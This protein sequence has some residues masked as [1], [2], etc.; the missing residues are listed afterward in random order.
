MFIAIIVFLPAIAL[1]VFAGIKPSEVSAAALAFVAIIAV[2]V[3]VTARSFSR[4]SCPR[5]GE[6]FAGSRDAWSRRD[7]LVLRKCTH[8]DLRQ[9][10]SDES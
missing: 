8:C 9:F 5:C 1:L 4:F 10:A 7:F 2:W 3:A 6:F